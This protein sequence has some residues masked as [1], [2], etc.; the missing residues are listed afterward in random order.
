MAGKKSMAAAEPRV[1]YQALA[2][3][4][5]LIFPKFPCYY[6]PSF[7]LIQIYN[8]LVSFKKNPRFRV[9]PLPNKLYAILSKREFFQ[10]DH[11]CFVSDEIYDRFVAGKKLNWLNL[12]YNNDNTS[13]TIASG[14]KRKS[15]SPDIVETILTKPNASI[16]VPVLSVA[17]CQSNCIFVSENCYQNLCTKYRILNEGQLFSVQ[18]QPMTADQYVPRLA[19]RATVFVIKN[20]YE[21][22]LDVTDEILSNFFF[23]PRILYRNHTYE[24]V[25]DEKLLGVALYSQYFHVFSMLKKIFF[26]V[27]HLESSDCAFENMAVVSKGATALH[28]STSINYPI[29]RQYLDDYCYL[30]ACPWGLLRY[31]NELKAC[32]LPFVGMSMLMPSTA[33]KCSNERLSASNSSRLLSNR[34]FPAFLLQSQRGAGKRR[35]VSAVAQSLGFQ[36]FSVDCAEIVSSIAAQT[37]A[38]LKLALAKA[39]I[40]EPLFFILHN[41]ELFGVDNEGRE[42]VRILTMFQKELHTLFAKQ[43]T[44]PIALIALS[45]KKNLKPIIQSQF[46]ETI[47]LEPP[48]KNERFNSLQ[49]MLHREIIMQEL[50]NSQRSAENDIPLWNGRSMKVAK[51][52]IARYYKC[53]RN[54]DVLQ[55]VADKTQG[56]LFGDLKLLFENSTK[57]MLVKREPNTLAKL[58]AYCRL[59]EFEKLLNE[60]QS[61]FSDSLGA[62]KVP[63]VLWS[64]IGGLAKL[65]DEIQSSIGLPLKHVHLMGKNMRR[66][67]ILLYGPPGTGK[68]LVAKAVATECNLSFLSVQ[69]PELLNMYVGQSEQNVR[70]GKHTHKITVTLM[71]EIDFGCSHSQ[72]SQEHVQ[73]R[74]VSYFSMSS[75]RLH[76]IAERLVIRVALW[77]ALSVNCWPKWM[78][79]SH[80]IRSNKNK[81]SFWQLPTDQ[82]SLIQHSCGPDASTNCSTLDRASQLMINRPYS[83]HK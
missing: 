32:V 6:F 47:S 22:P 56:F 72:F 38:K 36:Q 27:V 35:I 9:L 44:Y 65:K 33:S 41:F 58:E 54:L 23:L 2:Q 11:F 80:P 25:L 76:R 4:S 69:G 57:E 67:G 14:G 53:A 83:S 59:D 15:K 20:A 64:D 26:R 63:R 40:C 68:T 18:L 66:S 74:R 81:Y 34:I 60:M 3:A 79:W 43:R 51:L 12:V 52:Q 42:D 78:T 62:P 1:F 31:Y 21:L 7:L 39:N 13:S 37:E 30:S 46:L 77:I 55:E 19:T 61:D 75:T 5:K 71:T 73:R 50:F 82:I 48:N 16:L 8:K 49:W 17:K 28:Q 45:N 10:C 24:I 29:A 70:E